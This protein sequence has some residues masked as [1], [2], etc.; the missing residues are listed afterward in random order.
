MEESTG[1]VPTLVSPSTK[2]VQSTLV[3]ADRKF[4]L[5]SSAT[6]CALVPFVPPLVVSTVKNNLG[7]R[8]LEVCLWL[9]S[10]VD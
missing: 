10:G 2:S 3:G 8:I 7:Q 5:K 1:G 9:Q 6:D 4:K